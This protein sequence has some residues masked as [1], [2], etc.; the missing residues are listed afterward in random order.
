[1]LVEEPSMEAF[2]R[3]RLE[4]AIGVDGRVQM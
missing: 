2:L 1:V 3:G 4:T